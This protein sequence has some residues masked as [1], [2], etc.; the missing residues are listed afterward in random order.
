[1]DGNRDSVIALGRKQIAENRTD[2]CVVNGAAYGEGFGV[3]NE[4]GSVQ[5]CANAEGLY[6]ALSGL[7]IL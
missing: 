6:A 4:S 2:F 5:H 3:V 7:L 1:V